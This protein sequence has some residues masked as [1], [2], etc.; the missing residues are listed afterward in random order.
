LGEVPKAEGAS[1][2]PADI[3]PMGYFPPKEAAKSER[4]LKK[5]PPEN[6]FRRNNFG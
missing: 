1:H 2:S 5:H 3:V 4:V 6:L